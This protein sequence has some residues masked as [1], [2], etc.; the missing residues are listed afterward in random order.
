MS[1]EKFTAELRAASLRLDLTSAD[2]A[3]W[4]ERPRPTI[5]T[6]VEDRSAY[7]AHFPKRGR[8]LDECARR[9]TLLKASKDFPVPYHILKN[10]RPAYIKLAYRRAENAGV[11]A[12]RSARAG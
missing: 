4:F 5:R 7:N 6:W 11:P 9:L 10:E 8:V 2:L 12:R 3:L 1:P